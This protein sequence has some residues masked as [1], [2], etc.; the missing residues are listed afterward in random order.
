MK[1]QPKIAIVLFLLLGVMACKKNE[2][3]PVQESQ[4]TTLTDTVVRDTISANYTN[5]D[6]IAATN[7]VAERK[8]VKRHIP[9]KRW[10]QRQL[11]S[12]KTER[13]ALVTPPQ[14][15]G[16]SLTP[17]S[18]RAVPSNKKVGPGTNANMGSSTGN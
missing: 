1:N 12:I 8:S 7:Q 6:T 5:E 17:G 4:T 2:S 9:K 18:G 11:D 15:V 10:S 13:G 16:P 3:A 14:N